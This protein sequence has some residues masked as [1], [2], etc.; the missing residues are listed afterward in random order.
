M[1]IIKIIP[2][3]ALLAM[4]ACVKTVTVVPTNATGSTVDARVIVNGT[5]TG[6]GTTNIQVKDPVPVTVDGQPR[7]FS[8][9]FTVGKQTPS[10]LK[11]A[12]REDEIYAL[13]VDDTNK[14]VNV[15]LTL[16]IS[17]TA[18]KENGWWTTIINAIATQDFE[19]QLMDEK[20]GFV[21]TAW[22]ERKFGQRG[23]RRRFVGNIV[24]TAPLQWRVK[25]HVEV[26]KDGKNWKEFERG[27][28]EELDAIEEIRGRTQGN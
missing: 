21:R 3:L 20:S 18:A 15:W 25:Y 9:T 23:I 4:S 12:L 17:E 10:P 8:E 2:L 28:K 16:N 27:V 19:M 6:Q 1:K 22:K 13:T 24:S 14:V 11:V 5:P 26:T 7:Y